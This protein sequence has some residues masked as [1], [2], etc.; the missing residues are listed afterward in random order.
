[1]ESMKKEIEEALACLPGQP[2][3]GAGDAAGMLTFQFGLRQLRVSGKRGELGEFYEVGTWALHVQCP[4]HLASTHY[5][6]VGSGDRFSD[7]TQEYPDRRYDIS[8]PYPWRTKEPTLRDERLYD[9]FKR[10][11]HRPVFV[12]GI[13][14]NELGGVTLLLSYGFTLTIFPNSSNDDECWR[15]FRVEGDER[16]FVILG[17][18]LEDA[19]ELDDS[20]DS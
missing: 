4:W 16:H 1:M 17:N 12:E 8:D 3:W 7:P 10:C 5:L 20:A 15:F 6:L 13:Q 9:F 11:E 14:A 19:E 2:F 18:G